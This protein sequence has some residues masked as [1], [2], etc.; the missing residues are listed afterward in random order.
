MNLPKITTFD[1]EPTALVIVHEYSPLSSSVGDVIVKLF[2]F[3]LPPIYFS[4]F[5]SSGSP[6]LHQ[7]MCLTSGDCSKTL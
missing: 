1:I 5:L 4:L 6:F 7:F 3:R 2:S